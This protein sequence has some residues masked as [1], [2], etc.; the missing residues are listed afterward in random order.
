M[1]LLLTG[2]MQKHFV[3]GIRQDK[4]KIDVP[5]GHRIALVFRYGKEILMDLDSG[6]TC[7][8]LMPRAKRQYHFGKDIPGLYEGFR[9]SRTK[10]WT[11]GYH[12]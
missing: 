1:S 7:Y 3:H 5:L 4:D 6:K 11:A 12:G 2:K 9:Y 10:L 8:D